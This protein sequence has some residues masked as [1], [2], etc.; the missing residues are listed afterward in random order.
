D[1]H[2]SWDD[3]SGFEFPDWS[4]GLQFVVPFGNNAARAARDRADLV[5]EESRRT[6]YAAEL[7]VTREVREQLRTLRTLA[8]SIEAA[9]EAVRRGEVVLHTELERLKVGRGT[10]FDVQERYRE[11]LD[12]RQRLLHNHHGY[13]AAQSRLRHA[14]V[15]LLAPG[16]GRSG[17]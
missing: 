10:L 13:R 5:L 15:L 6:L 1:F 11:L 7:T 12:A 14:Q 16:E 17:L 4:L 9:L 3:A 2:D 8:T